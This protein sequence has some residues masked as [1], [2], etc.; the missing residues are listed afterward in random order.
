MRRMDI[1]WILILYKHLIKNQTL[2]LIIKYSHNV[3]IHDRIK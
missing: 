3:D 2:K 1:H